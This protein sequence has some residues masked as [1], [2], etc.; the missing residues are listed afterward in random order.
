M[1]GAKNLDNFAKSVIAISF[2]KQDPD[3][4]YIK[5]T[6][7]RNRTDGYQPFDETNVIECVI[8][9]SDGS[10]QYDF[11]G[12]SNEQAHLT[13]KDDSEVEA[14]AIR[15]AY[16]DRVRNGT[17]FRDIATQL[18]QLYDLDWAHTTISRKLVAYNKERHP[19]TPTDDPVG[20]APD[21][22]I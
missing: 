3:K 10:L 20:L 7:C 22:P 6:K 11:Y 18:K 14:E 12:F 19:H 16:E 13:P 21:K 15:F 9:R 1:A 5:Q 8:G 4:R 2:S 17:S